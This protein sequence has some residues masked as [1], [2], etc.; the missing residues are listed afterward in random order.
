[1]FPWGCWS[2]FLPAPASHLGLQGTGGQERVRGQR[3]QPWQ[4]L[5]RSRGPV[6]PVGT[7]AG[8]A[9]CPR[10]PQPFSRA[11]PEKPQ[12]GGPEASQVGRADVGP[13]LLEPGWLALECWQGP[14]VPPSLH[15]PPAGASTPSTSR[16]PR[17]I[18]NSPKLLKV[19]RT[20]GVGEKTQQLPS[21]PHPF[22]D[23]G[24]LGDL[25]ILDLRGETALCPRNIDI[26]EGHMAI[27]RFTHMPGV[28]SNTHV[29]VQVQTH[30]T[31]QGH[32]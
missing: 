11:G 24:F 14:G 31:A 25:V 7:E 12:V 15:P 23:P 17:A 5:D 4:V 30:A 2:S 20:W 29:H 3:K 27:P 18:F 13:T 9:D 32:P 1:M 19:D 26:Q 22:W 16:G 10:P 8:Q 28:Q 6:L 21:C